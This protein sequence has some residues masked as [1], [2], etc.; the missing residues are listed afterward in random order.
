MAP[1]VRIVVAAASVLALG[2]QGRAQGDAQRLPSASGAWRIE[3][4][5]DAESNQENFSL[6]TS[7]LGDKDATLSLWCKPDLSLFYFAVRDARLA[8]LP[9]GTEVTLSIRYPNE[10]AVRWQVASRGDGSIVVQER[11]H[12]TA[13]SLTLA[14]LKQ[15]SAAAAEFAIDGHQWTF[16]LEGFARSLRALIEACA[17]EPDPARARTSDRPPPSIDLERRNQLNL[18]LLLPHAR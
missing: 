4:Q 17:F 7:A 1:V 13:F 11:V 14:S 3:A 8:A 6:A 5:P 16:S 2:V 10:E 15:T 9:S 18:R 12:Q